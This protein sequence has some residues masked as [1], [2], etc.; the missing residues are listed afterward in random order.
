MN[1]TTSFPILFMFQ[2]WTCTMSKHVLAALTLIMAQV[3]FAILGYERLGV[4]KLTQ[5][6]N[7]QEAW[8]FTTSKKKMTTVFKRWSWAAHRTSLRNIV[9]TLNFKWISRYWHPLAFK[10]DETPPWNNFLRTPPFPSISPAPT[11][12]RRRHWK[13]TDCGWCQKRAFRQ[14]KKIFPG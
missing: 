7:M 12:R 2:L 14:I 1:R 6:V 3:T 5:L 10:E 8:V 13:L 4:L 9:K 11:G